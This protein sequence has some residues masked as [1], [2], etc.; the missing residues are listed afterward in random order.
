[1]GSEA[2]RSAAARAPH[3]LPPHLIS[4]LFQHHIEAP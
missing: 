3:S 2:P 1:M 4:T